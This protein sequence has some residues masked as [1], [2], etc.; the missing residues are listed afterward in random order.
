VAA[1]EAYA[2]H[3]VGLEEPWYY[4]GAEETEAR[5]CDAGF[6]EVRCWLQP[7]EVIPPDPVE[8]MRTLILDCLPENLNHRFLADVLEATGEPLR[9]ATSASTSRPSRCGSP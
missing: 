1:G 7:W 5:L 4:A 8:F 9:R 3:L 6:G 2:S